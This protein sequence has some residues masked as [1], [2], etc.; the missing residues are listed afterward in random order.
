M[1]NQNQ[2][3]ILS[4]AYGSSILEAVKQMD[5][6]NYKL[7]IVTKE[8]RYYSLISIGD[9]QR[10]I[11]KQIPLETPIEK[12]LRNI[13][14]L[15]VASSNQ[16]FAEIKSLMVKHR[17]EFMPVIDSAGNLVNLFLWEDIF[18]TEERENKKLH[19]FPVVIMAGGKGTRLQPIT[20]IIPKALVPLG[21]KPMVEEIIDRFL[22]IGCTKFYLTV[23]YKYELIQQYFKTQ[24]P[25]LDIHYII[26]DKFL[27]TA[28]SLSYLKNKLNNTFFLHNCD[29]IVDQNYSD[30]YDYHADNKNELTIVSAL[31]HY[32]IPYGTLITG[33][34]GLLKSLEEKPEL[35]FMINTGL[36]ILEPN[37]LNQI[38]SNEF[39]HIT[40]LINQIKDRNGKVGVFPVS[41]KS[42]MD[43]GVW[44]EYD[45]TQQLFKE[46]FS[47]KK[48]T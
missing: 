24:R 8:G 46:R 27:G 13:D 5:E 17:A 10:A 42:W 6:V 37:L 48:N 3:N 7:L 44:E 29:I 4:I 28:G 30:I 31:K 47:P 14:E 36:Y 38:P 2:I 25:E 45:K 23:N 22:A 32:K 21:E 41:E 39:Y 19:N 18:G 16:P 9:I 11:V 34:N 20:N 26:E 15:T 43:I 12:V 1:K 40:D 35:T 33:E